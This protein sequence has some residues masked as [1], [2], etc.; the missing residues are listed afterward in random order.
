[1]AVVCNILSLSCI[2]VLAWF[3]TSHSGPRPHRWW[4]EE[5]LVGEAVHLKATRVCG[6]EVKAELD[7]DLLNKEGGGTKKKLRLICLRH[8]YMLAL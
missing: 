4:E 8:N 1:M 5:A 6:C 7:H 2:H 3:G